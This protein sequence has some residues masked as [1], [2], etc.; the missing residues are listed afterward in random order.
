MVSALPCRAPERAAVYIYRGIDRKR[1]GVH[2]ARDDGDDGGA[3]RLGLLHKLGEGVEQLLQSLR[4][5]HH[6]GPSVLVNYETHRAHSGARAEMAERI[7][8]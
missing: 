3:G 4:R 8:Q 1:F 5:Y 2:D 7:G 6:H